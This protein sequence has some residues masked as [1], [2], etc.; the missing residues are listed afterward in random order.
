MID[1]DVQMGVSGGRLYRGGR[2]EITVALS[3]NQ[4]GCV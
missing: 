3:V 4:S 1:V 2:G